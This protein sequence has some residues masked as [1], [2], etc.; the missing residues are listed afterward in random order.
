MMIEK[1]KNLA[2]SLVP[3][4]EVVYG[5]WLCFLTGKETRET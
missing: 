3:G 4:S 1:T 5:E 2:E